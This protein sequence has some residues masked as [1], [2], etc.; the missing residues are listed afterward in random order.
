MS[1]HSCDSISIQPEDFDL[2]EE[3]A[4]LRE[5]CGGAVG[6][7]AS[8]VGLVRDAR[9]S[10]SAAA[11]ES[12]PVAELFL[13]HYPGVT[14]A[15]I[16]QMLEAARQRWELLGIRV[17]HR[18]GALGPCDQ[19]VLVLVAAGHRPAAFAAC[20]FLMDYLKTDAVLWKRERGAG[21]EQWL[22]PSEMD[23]QRRSGW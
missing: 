22:E 15:S 12:E 14:E 2:G 9:P 11:G 3:L 18:V 17:I 1:S 21:G 8:F 16:V 7:V 6:A 23:Q 4:R 19:I 5:R 10:A 20:E 13:E